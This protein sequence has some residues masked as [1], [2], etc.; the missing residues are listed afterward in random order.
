MRNGYNG[1]AEPTRYPGGGLPP[2]RHAEVWHIAGPRNHPQ[3]D[4]RGRRRFVDDR[5]APAAHQ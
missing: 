2:L 4:R 1:A 3:R 5:T